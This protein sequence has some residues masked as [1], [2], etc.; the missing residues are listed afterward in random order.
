M[1]APKRRSGPQRE[2]V[3][4]IALRTASFLRENINRGPTA[5]ASTLCFRRECRIF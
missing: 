2:A 3:A 5:I 4:I 1:P